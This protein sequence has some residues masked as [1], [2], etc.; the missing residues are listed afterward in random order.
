MV[1]KSLRD[2][3]L[4]GRRR[5]GSGSASISPLTPDVRFRPIADIKPRVQMSRHARCPIRLSGL[6]CAGRVLAS[7]IVVG[8]CEYGRNGGRERDCSAPD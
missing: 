4:P 3:G 1:K 6:D 8:R 5:I 7:S 2:C